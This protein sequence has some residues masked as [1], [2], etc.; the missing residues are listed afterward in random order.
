MYVIH[1]RVLIFWNNWYY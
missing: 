1:M